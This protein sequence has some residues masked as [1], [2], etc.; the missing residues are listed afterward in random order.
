VTVGCGIVFKL[1]PSGEETTLYSFQPSPDANIP[2]SALVRD[3]AG[4]F[5][6]TTGDGG[7]SSN[8]TFGESGCGTVFK[9]DRSGNESVLYSFSGTDGSFPTVGLITDAAGNLYGT[10][11]HGGSGNAGTV[12]KIIP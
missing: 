3:S 10:T 1:S 7:S 2:F 6:G 9:L 11:Q 12:F 4:N 8:C 5:Y